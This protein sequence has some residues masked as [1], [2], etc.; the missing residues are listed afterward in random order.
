MNRDEGR[1]ANK[2]EG[3][4]LQER[5][6]LRPLSRGPAAARGAGSRGALDKGRFVVTAKVKKKQLKAARA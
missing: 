4:L 2:A 5:P 1:Q 6:P 3:P